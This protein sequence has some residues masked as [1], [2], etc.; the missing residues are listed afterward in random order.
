MA[1]GSFE[2]I[3]PSR[4]FLRPGIATGI[5]SLRRPSLSLSRMGRFH[6]VPLRNAT[7]THARRWF[8]PQS[9]RAR[10]KGQPSCPDESLSID[11]ELSSLNSEPGCIKVV[12]TFRAP[13]HSLQADSS[14]LPGPNLHAVFGRKAGTTP[15]FNYSAAM[16]DSGV[17]WNERTLDQF[18]AAPQ[19]FIPSDV[20]PF[21][22]LAD[23]T[24]RQRLIGYLKAA[25]R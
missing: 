23:K 9:A 4:A 14:G 15:G 19:T 22:G 8:D 12:D 18:I 25:T 10:T 2:V 13:C 16:R 6:C 20:M 7:R 5:D 21:P 24:A 11:A 1:P 17:V 3:E